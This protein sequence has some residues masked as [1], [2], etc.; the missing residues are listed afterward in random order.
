MFL[1][2]VIHFQGD[3]AT[4]NLSAQSFQI[5]IRFLETHFKMLIV[6]PNCLGTGSEASLLFHLQTTSK[7]ISEIRVSFTVEFKELHGLM[8][9]KALVAFGNEFLKVSYVLMSSCRWLAFTS[10][11]HAE[12]STPLHPGLLARKEVGLWDM[13]SWWRMHAAHFSKDGLLTAF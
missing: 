9:G 13:R 4:G 12:L 10:C 1:N 5:L 8:W 6:P 2:S 7:L 3:G 11:Q